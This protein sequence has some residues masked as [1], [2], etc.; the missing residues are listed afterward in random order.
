MATQANIEHQARYNIGT[1]LFQYINSN[2]KCEPHKNYYYKSIFSNPLITM[3]NIQDTCN[4]DSEIM[5]YVSLNP[6]ITTGLIKDFP[7]AKW[8]WE[9]MSEN[10]GIT[11]DTICNFSNKSW[12]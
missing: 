7:E 6:N 3:L 8:N 10:K 2:L 5:T 4:K 1:K 9:L 11:M 12:I